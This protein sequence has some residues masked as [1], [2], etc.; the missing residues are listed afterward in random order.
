MGRRGARMP[1]SRYTRRVTTHHVPPPTAYRPITTQTI[2]RGTHTP[3]AA[4]DD[5]PGWR[6][7]DTLRRKV[8]RRR[9]APRATRRPS[10]DGR[11]RARGISFYFFARARRRASRRRARTT[12]CTRR[13]SIEPRSR[14]NRDPRAAARSSSVGHRVDA[15]GVDSSATRIR[16]SDRSMAFVRDAGRVD[17]GRVD[18]GPIASAH[19][20]SSIHRRDRRTGLS[21]VVFFES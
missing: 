10:R 21:V 8:R 5:R 14:S 19:P 2:R 13:A 17:E 1:K 3:T 15:R 9:D 18:D 6:R 4:R 11:R 12:R 7:A 20:S 16:A